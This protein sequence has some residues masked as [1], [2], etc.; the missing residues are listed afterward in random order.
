LARS[1]DHLRILAAAQQDT[2]DRA[3][4]IM[5]RSRQAY[6]KAQAEGDRDA[7]AQA[8]AAY[9]DAS[10]TL[11][12]AQAILYRIQQAILR[13]EPVRPPPVRPPPPPPPPPASGK[14]VNPAE[15]LTKLKAQPKTTV[16]T[17]WGSS[18]LWQPQPQADK[19]YVTKLG[20]AIL[21]KQGVG[22]EGILATKQPHH[23]ADRL[24][25]A[26]GLQNRW[27][28]MTY[29]MD[30]TW[31]DILVQKIWDEHAWYDKSCWSKTMQRWYAG[32]EPEGDGIGSQ[33]FQDVS[34]L[35]EMLTP[36]DIWNPYGTGAP[37]EV[38]VDQCAA[39]ECGLPTGGRPSYAFSW[40]EPQDIPGP[41]KIH[42]NL[43]VLRSH[44]E[45]YR[46]PN[47]MASGGLAYSFGGI[48]CHAYRNVLIQDTNVFYAM[49]DRSVIQLW[50]NDSVR[51]IGGEV[52]DNWYGKTL[53]ID[54]RGVPGSKVEVEGLQGKW[55]ARVLRCGYEGW[56][57]FQDQQIAPYLAL[58]H[59]S[60][61]AGPSFSITL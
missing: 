53:D 55:R 59:E 36:S 6:R 16:A 20:K 25:L 58:T 12:A 35:H 46:H 29:G 10:A 50:G 21:I 37:A 56:Y 18:V 33:C 45:S 9:D 7:A 17:D 26:G 41:M 39:I 28:A 31:T 60:A 43:T 1:I 52:N 57:K 2:I 23:I 30:A 3:S 51:I 15:L 22:P 19:R 5:F 32:G 44:L 27:G 61:T 49:P 34:R 42:R 54:I 13:E 40:F 4:A 8:Q 11:Q 24:E 38:L 47:Y 48:M 14:A